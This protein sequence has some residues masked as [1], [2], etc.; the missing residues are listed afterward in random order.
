MPAANLPAGQISFLDLATG[1]CND[2]SNITM[3]NMATRANVSTVDNQ[4]SIDEFRGKQI[5]Y[6][7]E[8]VNYDDNYDYTVQYVDENCISQ[9]VQVGP[10]QSH[11]FI[12]IPATVSASGTGAL[13]IN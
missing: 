10:N 5:L 2:T 3:F 9:V 1:T 6:S 13:F 8:A 4:I 11:F 12:A 7:Y